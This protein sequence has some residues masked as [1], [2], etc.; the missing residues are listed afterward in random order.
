[1]QLLKDDAAVLAL[2]GTRIHPG[3]SAQNS[4]K[5]YLVTQMVANEHHEQLSGSAGLANALMQINGYSTSKSEV[6]DLREKVRL[7]LQG[8]TPGNVTVGGDTFF[9]WGIHLD[10][11]R[12]I[13]TD[14]RDG[15]DAEIFGFSLDF[16]VG[17]PEPIP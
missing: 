4:A 2:V 14:P 10:G 16:R 9:V 7:A 6:L 11:D 1:M 17:Y 3:K 15:S 5:P 12:D 13:D 8:R